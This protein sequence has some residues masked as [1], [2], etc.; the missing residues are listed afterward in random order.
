MTTQ[1]FQNDSFSYYNDTIGNNKT[2]LTDFRNIDRI[3]SLE[4]DML[5]KVDRVSML[6]SI[7]CRAP[8]LNKDL[9]NFT[10][11][12]PESFLIKGWDKKHLLKETFKD[13]FPK[14]FL[15]KSKKGFGVP[16]GDWLRTNLKD[17]LLS[18]V[19]PNFIKEQQIFNYEFVD[20]MIQDHLA[21]RVDNTFRVW[22]FF[23]FQMWYKNILKNSII[24]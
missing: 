14:G 5:V 13:Y 21:K 12:L 22:T 1:F 23:C 2:T 8:F 11:Q 4:G 17:E 20:K 6:N 3:L 15:D 24:K 9:W 7:E 19:E 18:F 10:S 16:V